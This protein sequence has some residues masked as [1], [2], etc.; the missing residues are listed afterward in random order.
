MLLLP[1]WLREFVNI[2]VDDTRLADDLTMAGIS[3]EGVTSENGHTVYDVDITPNRVDAMNHYGVAR[4]CAAVYNADLKSPKADLP[5]GEGTAKFAIEIADA[6]G[7]ARYTS[8]I[9]RGVTIKPSPQ[10]VAE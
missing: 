5:K 3:I 2:P 10:K 8:R 4:D 1:S 9:L 7:C 6:E